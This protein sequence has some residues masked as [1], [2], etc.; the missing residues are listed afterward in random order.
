MRRQRGL[1]G[2]CASVR[3]GDLVRV[4]VDALERVDGNQNLADI[5]LHVIGFQGTA[6]ITTQHSTTHV[7]PVVHVSGL[8]RGVELLVGQVGHLRH[9]LYRSQL[10]VH[11]VVLSSAKMLVRGAVWI[12]AMDSVAAYSAALAALALPGANMCG[13]PV[14]IIMRYRLCAPQLSSHGSQGASA[15][16]GMH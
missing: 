3:C 2:V 9:V 14:D 10:C 11:R 7:Y 8:E 6:P 1:G 4:D 5:G 12:F 16:S 15:R 13:H